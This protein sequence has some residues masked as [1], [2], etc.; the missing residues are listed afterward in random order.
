[1]S[2]AAAGAPTD[3]NVVASRAN[4]TTSGTGPAL[5]SSIDTCSASDDEIFAIRA[6][7]NRTAVV[8][9]RTGTVPSAF[10]VARTLTFAALNVSIVLRISGRE[11]ANP[12]HACLRVKPIP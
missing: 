10:A 9:W 1:M 11:V 6:D 3:N 2:G 5:D 7:E 8:E 12:K 4:G